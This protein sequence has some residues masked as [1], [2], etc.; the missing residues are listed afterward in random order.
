MNF[1]ERLYDLLK[2]KEVGW[3]AAKAF[4]NI[5]DSDTILT[6]DNHANV[7]VMRLFITNSIA[8][9][10]HTKILYAQKY[11][12]VILPKLVDLARTGNGDNAVIHPI[13][14]H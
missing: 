11:V 13:F 5:V 12:S 2:D 1:S 4:G 14:C 3:E 6:K 7:K 8:N 10:N 9:Q